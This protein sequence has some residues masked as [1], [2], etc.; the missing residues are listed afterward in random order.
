MMGNVMTQ[1]SYAGQFCPPEIYA[2]RPNHEKEL[3]YFK[4]PRDGI[5]I[6]TD[7]RM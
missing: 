2:A 3:G 5:E 6:K 1:Q 7:T 4:E